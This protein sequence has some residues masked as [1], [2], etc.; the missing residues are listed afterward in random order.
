MHM[1]AFQQEK[2]TFPHALRANEMEIIYDYLAFSSHSSKIFLF[3]FASAFFW[4][5]FLSSKEIKEIEK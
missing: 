5:L 2:P 4:I 1:K 3:A